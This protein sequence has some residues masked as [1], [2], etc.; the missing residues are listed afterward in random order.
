MNYN[1]EN[2][3]TKF[4]SF[5]LDGNNLALDFINTLEYRKTEKEIDWITSYKDA[6]CWAERTNILSFTQMKKLLDL[7]HNKDPEILNIQVHKYRGNL[8]DVFASIIDQTFNKIE[9][10]KKFNDIYSLV[11][12]EI[13]LKTD[14]LN[15]TWEYPELET[16]PIG[17][18]EPVIQSAAD[19]L[20]S[21]NLER[22]K[23]CS[24]PICGWLYYDT[25]KNNSRRWCCMKKCGNR[26]KANKFYQSHK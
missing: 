2:E 1:I 23:R 14:T 10:K 12:R 9:I 4:K 18:L 8:Y 22:L 5:D 20:V 3:R 16:N 11:K 15:F 13:N 26:A 17:F 6:L 21:G 24:N 19:L 7:I 25:S